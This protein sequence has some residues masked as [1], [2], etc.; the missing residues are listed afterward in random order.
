MPIATVPQRNTF[1]HF[2][3]QGL[4]EMSL[5]RSV[6][7]PGSFLPLARANSNTWTPPAASS[8]E[9]D[10]AS[11]CS[12]K[13]PLNMV[14]LVFWPQPCEVFGG[15]E[16]VLPLPRTQR[17][18]PNE[19]QTLGL[20]LPVTS[21]S[22]TNGD[23]RQCIDL[24]EVERSPVRQKT[25]TAISPCTA[26]EKK[27]WSDLSEDD[28]SPMRQ[29]LATDPSDGEQGSADQK[30]LA[31][32][33][34]VEKRRWADLSED[35]KTPILELACTHFFHSTPLPQTSSPDLA[36]DEQSTVDSSCGEETVGR[37]F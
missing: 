6:T 15:K 30:L 37:P 25:S 17:I 10:Y 21:T 9:F 33:T 26:A 18:Q 5:D 32:L 20:L 28:L 14:P 31:G 11:Y 27:R 36:D 19:V 2:Q 23:E 4:D 16:D 3:D 24:S 22:P 7:C 8:L 13:S 12:G 1:I 35:E 34:A 29:M